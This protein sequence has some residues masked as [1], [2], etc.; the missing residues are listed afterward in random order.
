MLFSLACAIA[1]SFG[2]VTIFALE[3]ACLKIVKKLLLW[4]NS[5][6]FHIH[7]ENVPVNVPF[8]SSKFTLNTPKF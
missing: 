8:Q 5:Y 3:T 7:R 4:A 6:G 1:I 2:L